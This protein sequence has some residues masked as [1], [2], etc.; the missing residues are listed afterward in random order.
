MFPNSSMWLFQ[1][2]ALYTE[3]LGEEM[4]MYKDEYEM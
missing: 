4:G 1:G 2:W 3:Y